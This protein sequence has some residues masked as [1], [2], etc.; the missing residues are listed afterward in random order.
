MDILDTWTGFVQNAQRMTDLIGV[1]LLKVNKIGVQDGVQDVQDWL[2]QVRHLDELI[3]T[4]IAERDQLMN[5]ATKC[6]PNMDGMP[7][8]SGTS[9]KV[10]NIAVK[11]AD[12]A[13]EIDDLIDYYVDYKQN[14][15]RTLQ[16]LDPVEYLILYKYYI[17]GMTIATI[18][19]EMHYHRVTISNKKAEAIEHLKDAT[20]CC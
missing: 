19:D 11:L 1:I 10:G 7:H 9:D 2:C 20:Q 12:M 5:L 17:Q 3:N 13:A 8:G 16:K 18:A 14:V 4:K 6:T 15:V